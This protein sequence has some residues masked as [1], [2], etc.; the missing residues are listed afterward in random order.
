MISPA[1]LAMVLFIRFRDAVTMETPATPPPLPT[2]PIRR[3]VDELPVAAEL[4]G[5]AFATAAF[6]SDALVFSSPCLK[7][8]SS[9]G[10]AIWSEP[11][12]ALTVTSPPAEMVTR[13]STIACTLEYST[14]T[15]TPTPTPAT[16]PPPMLPLAM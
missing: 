3:I 11:D 5:S 14:A 15:D 6:I 10:F 7:D 8:K 1:I 16:P 4:S 2:T 12:T 13:S 9:P